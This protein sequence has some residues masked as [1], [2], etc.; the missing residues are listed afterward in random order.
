MRRTAPDLRD[1][2]L[3]RLPSCPLSTGATR[4]PRW[5]CGRDGI[6]RPRHRLP[7]RACGELVFNTAI[8]G[9][10]EI[11]TDP[12]YAGQIVT[13]T[14]PHIG[15]VGTNAGG[16]RGADPVCKGHGHPRPDHRPASNWRIEP[17]A[18]RLAG[19]AAASPRIAG[20][21]TRRITRLLRDS[22]RPER[23]ALPTSRMGGSISR[24]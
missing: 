20:V 7:R 3:D 5:R 9:Y 23:G 2:S 11:L 15:N 22:R 21:D 4:P 16:Y 14:F 19:A 10:Q 1:L 12:S 6:S 13:F 8:T 18:R 24:R 17:C